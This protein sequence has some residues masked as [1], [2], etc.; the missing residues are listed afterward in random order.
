MEDA[1]LYVRM[2]LCDIFMGFMQHD[3]LITTMWK[4]ISWS[5]MISV[6]E[7]RNMKAL[8]GRE[9]MDEKIMRS[10]W[11]RLAS[12]AAN[13]PSKRRILKTSFMWE[14][15]HEDLQAEIDLDWQ[16]T[17][18]ITKATCDLEKKG[19]DKSKARA[20]LHILR[21]RVHDVESTD[22]QC[23]MCG[24]MATVKTFQLLFGAC[25]VFSLDIVFSNFLE[26]DVVSAFPGSI[27][28]KWSTKDLVTES[29]AESKRDEDMDFHCCESCYGPCMILMQLHA[30]KLHALSHVQ[31]CLQY[32]LEKVLGT[33][34]REAETELPPFAFESAF[35]DTK[36]TWARTCM[37]CEV[38]GSLKTALFMS[39]VRPRDFTKVFGSTRMFSRSPLLFGAGDGAKDAASRPPSTDRLEPHHI[40]SSGTETESEDEVF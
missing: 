11:R 27:P 26:D 35:A 33:K 32:S 12:L 28:E 20:F 36:A 34:E 25:E 40:P 31:Q 19:I 4:K 6:D 23:S 14:G 30:W 17:D 5:M 39:C 7:L 2:C 21:A 16:L 24:E 15:A 29:G 18:L 9:K 1:A 13:T 37:P 3:R 22:V 10:M 38:I 8:L